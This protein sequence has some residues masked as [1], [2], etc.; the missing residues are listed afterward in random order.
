MCSRFAFLLIV[1]ATVSIA[2]ALDG[3]SINNENRQLGAAICRCETEDDTFYDRRFNRRLGHRSSHANA[4]DQRRNLN[5]D[6]YQP[7]LDEDG[8]YVL[9]GVRILPSTDA[10]CD[11]SDSD[12]GERDRTYGSTSSSIEGFFNIFNGNRRYL[13][14]ENDID[15]EVLEEVE[16]T[17]L[18]DVY[19]KYSPEDDTSIDDEDDTYLESEADDG[20]E[21]DTDDY[22]DGDADDDDDDVDVDEQELQ[23]YDDDG[24]KY[25]NEQSYRRLMGMMSGKG[26]K[27][28]GSGKGGM[29]GGY[30]SGSG[31]GGSHYSYSKGK[32][33]MSYSYGKGKG[34]KGSYYSNHDDYYYVGYS[35]GKGKGKGKGYNYGDEIGRAHV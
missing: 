7:Y 4:D 22:A 24:S 19:K 11:G 16:S 17:Y 33:G 23:G 29:M 26:G 30:S 9:E 25:E 5:Y 28:G 14:Q 1:A 27:G 15:D 21:A 32:G 20:T 3:D 6:Y 35:K 31:K 12:A 8:Y 34:G 13:N 18:D 10:L 2:A